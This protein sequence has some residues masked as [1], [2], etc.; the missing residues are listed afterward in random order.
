MTQIAEVANLSRTLFIEKYTVGG[1]QMFG[2]YPLS[3]TTT[4]EGST[5]LE[6]LPFDMLLGIKRLWNFDRVEFIDSPVPDRSSGA[7]DLSLST[8]REDGVRRGE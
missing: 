6:P 5:Y 1:K 8:V 4:A 7:G 2:I 3:R